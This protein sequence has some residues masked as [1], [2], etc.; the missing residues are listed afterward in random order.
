M[1][2]TNEINFEMAAELDWELELDTIMEELR[3][4]VS[5]TFVETIQAGPP[6]ILDTLIEELHKAQDL[7][8][9]LC[10]KEGRGLQL[11]EI[12]KLFASVMVT[13]Q[14]CLSLGVAVGALMEYVKKMETGPGPGEAVH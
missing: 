12:N 10:D 3:K 4:K 9:R 14:H 5:N 13:S 2:D 8:K 7:A 1:S 6:L 11:D